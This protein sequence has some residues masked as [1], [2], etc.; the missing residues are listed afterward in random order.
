MSD[1]DLDLRAVEE[2]IK[3]DDEAGTGSETAIVLDVLNAET[4][5][6]ELLEAVAAG[7]VC[8]LCV[9]GDINRLAA[10]FARDIKEAG[11]N[12][13]HFRGFLVVTPPEIDVD[14]SRL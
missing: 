7:T 9:E 4:D 10:G 12:L 11:G 5:P 3:D 8:V 14:S 2:H 6:E 13:V 1:F